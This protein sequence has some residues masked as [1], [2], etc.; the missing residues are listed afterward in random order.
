VKQRNH[1]SETARREHIMGLLKR[2][3]GGHEEEDR[4]G[5]SVFEMPDEETET[6]EDRWISTLAAQRD[7][8]IADGS[9]YA[10][11]QAGARFQIEDMRRYYRQYGYASFQEAVQQS[12]EYWHAMVQQEQDLVDQGHDRQAHLDHAR[13]QRSMY[14]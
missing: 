12:G 14:D 2:I 7:Q 5:V 4:D 9:D 6:E 10:Q 3:F 1:S 11:G 8:E 13:G